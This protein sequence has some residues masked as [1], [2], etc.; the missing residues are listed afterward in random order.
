MRHNV[1]G[2]IPMQGAVIMESGPFGHSGESVAACAAAGFSA[3]STETISPHDGKSPPWNILRFGNS[4]YNCSA[5]SDIPLAQWCEKELPRACAAGAVVIASVGQC[6]EREVLSTVQRLEET[7]IAGYKVV[8]YREDAVRPLLRAVRQ[9]TQRPVWVKIS[10]NWAG[11]RQLALD[12]QALGAN[13]LVAIDSIG[14]LALPAGPWPVPGF[15]GGKG[16]LSGAA[17]HGRA[18]QVVACLADAVSIPVVGVGGVMDAAGVARMLAN[19]AAAVGVC[20]AVLRDGIG[21]LG[22]VLETLNEQA[23]PTLATHP[24]DAPFSLR[25]KESHCRGCGACVRQCG[26]FAL[27]ESDRTP[28]FIQDK[29]RRCGLCIQACPNGAIYEEQ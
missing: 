23:C 19:G 14:P 21:W 4:F 15:A 16:W 13:A 17:I 28:V 26:Y 2:G 5:W 24:L 10:A 1:I 22:P 20:S 12:C 27:K 18:L 25:I 8:A 11:Y 6:S 7:S 9:C 29:C 3:V